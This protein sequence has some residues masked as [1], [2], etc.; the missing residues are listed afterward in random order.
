MSA[1]PVR[2]VVV[3]LGL[4]RNAITL[5]GQRSAP[6]S[7]TRRRATTPIK[8][9]GDCAPTYSGRCKAIIAST[10]CAI[11][12]RMPPSGQLAALGTD[13]NQRHVL[14]GVL[15]VWL[16]VV[17]VPHLFTVA[18]RGNEPLTTMGEQCGLDPA[19]ALIQ[20][21]HC[22]TAALNCPVCPTMSPLAKL[23]TIKS[24]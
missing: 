23:T 19:D 21:F 2:A 15:G 24:Y 22:G 12:A 7:G 18:D 5:V 9:A 13:I 20:Y 17:V 16:V 4:C 8:K 10:V 11:S 14:G 6:E 1:A 3:G